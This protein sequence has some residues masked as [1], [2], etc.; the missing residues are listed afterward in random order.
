MCEQKPYLSL[1]NSSGV[2]NKVRC[3]LT[4]CERSSAKQVNQEEPGEESIPRLR[5]PAFLLCA[6]LKTAIHAGYVRV[7]WSAQ[8]KGQISSAKLELMALD[9]V[10]LTAFLMNEMVYLIK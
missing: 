4:C 9:I 3:P 7:N 6:S 1:V 5:A 10:V 8:T 2:K